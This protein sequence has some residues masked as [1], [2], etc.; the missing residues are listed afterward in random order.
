[1]HSDTLV[2]DI[3]NDVHFSNHIKNNFHTGQ[4]LQL[5]KTENGTVYSGHVQLNVVPSN[6][7][8]DSTF[9]INIT[10]SARGETQKHAIDRAEKIDYQYEVE[11]GLIKFSPFYSFPLEDRYRVQLIEVVVEVP[12]GKAVYLSNNMT[13]IIYDIKNTTNTYDGDM[14]GLTWTMTPEGLTCIGCNLEEG[15][16]WE[17]SR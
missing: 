4:P 7:I 12:I 3:M 16:R 11:D 17:R 13:R 2:L 5:I 14:V 1:M 10:R 9:V 15:K 8:N 6:T